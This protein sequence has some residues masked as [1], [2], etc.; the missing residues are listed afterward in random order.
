[1]SLTGQFVSAQ[2]PMAHVT[3]QAHAVAQ[4]TT[5]HAP[6]PV[7]STVQALLPHETSPQA[8]LPVHDTLQLPD[9]LQL[10]FEHPPFAH[11][12]SHVPASAQL[13]GPHAFI[14]EQLTVHDVALPQ[15][16]LS[17]PL[18]TLEVTSHA[19]SA[20]QLNDPQRS[21]LVHTMEHVRVTGSHVVHTDGHRLASGATTATT[22]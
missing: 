7:Q 16:M 14:P 6:G 9:V 20:G 5:S 17:A 13:T 1:M 4:L 2:L 21:P 12:T 15:L 11:V 18:L 3:S 22:Q 8:L 10:T 19:Q